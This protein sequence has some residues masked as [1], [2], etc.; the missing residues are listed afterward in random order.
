MNEVLD[1]LYVFEMANNHQGSVEHGLRIIEAAARISHTHKIRGAVKLQ[2]RD[3]DSF[4]HPDFKGQADVP[5]I[6][7]FEST[8]LDKDDMP[9]EFGAESEYYSSLTPQYA[10]KN[11]PLERLEE[12]LLVRGVTPELLFGRDANRNGVVDA[13][14]GNAQMVGGVDNSDGLLDRGWSAF[15]TLHSQE[16]NAR[17]DGSPKI[18]INAKDLKKLHN[19]LVEA[20]GDEGMA[21]FI[22]AY[23]QYGPYSGSSSG[24]RTQSAESL[25]IDT[26]QEAK[27]EL[28]SV[29]DLI[30]AQVSIPQASGGSPRGGQEIIVE[31]P[32]SS[33]SR[34][35]STYLPL[36]MDNLSTESS[37]TVAGRI[38]INQA[39]RVVL[40]AVP[41][42]TEGAVEDIINQR[43]QE[44][45]PERPDRRHATWLL[46]ENIVTLDEM[47][48]LLPLLNGGGDVYRAQIVG[49]FGQD[50]PAARAEIILDATNTTSQLLL[51]RDIGHLGRGYGRDTLGVELD[52]NLGE[53]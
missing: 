45:T 8:R 26:S 35:I 32:F 40:S 50:G 36:L 11:G 48:Q 13:D 28:A 29:L 27:V 12:L 31:A 4:I 46:G 34:E 20:L 44:V 33:E 39:S 47:K 17:P 15:L 42:L 43:D 9:R 38:N 53:H 6:P 22:I 37:K 3:L 51:W 5:H 19:S 52:Q 41:Q 49:F 24:K 10:A 30:G 23:R 21:N 14:E 7:R 25:S 2:F 18:N 1:N 16:K